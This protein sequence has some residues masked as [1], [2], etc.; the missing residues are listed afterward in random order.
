MLEKESLE[1]GLVTG[2]VEYSM[3]RP[4]TG[5]SAELPIVLWLHGGGGSARFL[6][7]CQAQFVACWTERSLPDLIAVTP[8]A[9][10]SYYLD[11]RDGGELWESFLFDELVPHIRKKTGSTS[12]PLV[13]GG[14]SVGGL[15]ALRLA[16]RRPGLVGAVVAIEPTIEAAMAADEVG[17]RD[18]IHM[19]RGLRARLYG[20]PIDADYW[21]DNHP[22]ALVERNGPAIVASRMAIYVEC[23]DSDALHAQF[24][25]ELLHRQ[26]FEAGISHEYRMVRGGNH[27]GPTI[28]PRVVDA[29]RFVGG[30]LKPAPYDMLSINAMVEVETFTTQVRELERAA[31]YRQRREVRGPDCKLTVHVQGEGRPVVLLPSLGRGPDDFADLADRLARAGCRVL[32]PE[33]RGMAG[34]SAALSD[35]TLDDFADDVAAVI[36]AFGGPA[37]VVGHDFGGQVAQMVAYLYPDLVSSLVLLAAPGPIQPKP[38]PATALRRVFIPELSDEEHLEAVALALFADGNDPVVWVDG[39]YP[40]VAYAQAEA[41]RHVPIED[42]WARLR[43]EAL[44]V[45]PT[46]DLIV[47]PRNAERMAE[48][49]GDLVTVVEIPDAGHALLPEQPEAVAAAVLSWLK[50][51]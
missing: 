26:L 15:A 38:E 30:V 27:V 41:E 21:L 17:L 42:L 20:D 48:Q 39:W 47:L 2:P 44:V 32:R 7:T 22:A 45:Q 43:V 10:W 6:E 29:L 4:G 34:S 23:G 51:H 14:I 40:M 50:T 16:F 28:G 33:P 49:L 31:G 35:L 8:T 3:L 19:P 9:G 13:V 18:L 36:D 24:G 5:P 46:D 37:M 11:R 12:G 25:A 1:T